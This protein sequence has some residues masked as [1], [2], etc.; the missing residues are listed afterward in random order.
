MKIA[1]IGAGFGGLSA[2]WDLRRAGH[3]V[4][5]FEAAD[6]VGGLASGF[7]APHWDWSVDKFYHHWFA[8]DKHLLNLM[9]E[10]GW[11]EDVIYPRPFTVLYYRDKWYPFD[12]IKEALLFPGLGYGLD[13]IRFGLVGVY[14]RLTNN[15]RTLENVTADAW[16]RRWAGEKVY[17]LMWEPLLQGKFGEKY[18]RQVNMAWMWAR[19][20]ARTTRLG[21]FKGGFQRF[22]DRFANRLMEMGVHI[23]LSTP[24]THLVQRGGQWQLETAAGSAEFERVLVTVSPHALARMAPDLP[25]DYLENLLRLK[26]MGAI[27][28]VFALKHQLSTEGY[29]WFN[30]PKAEGFPALALVEH[31]NFVSPEHFGGDH[32]VYLGDY[33]PPEH[34]YFRL[35]EAE[36]REIYLPA[37]KRINPNFSEDWVKQTWLFRAAYAQPIPL[38]GHSQHIPAVQ[39]PLDGLYYAGMSQ[40]YPWDRGTNYAIELGR[41]AAGLMMDN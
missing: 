26:H 10:L 30:L 38:T 31:T 6:Y 35:S 11:R 22:A 28:M 8:S 7:K 20:K 14:L 2:A 33:L 1:I 36:L 9:D 18:Y 21:T 12:A 37:L 40:V 17:R 15:W 41:R 27:V 24:V 3:E 19:L 32:I 4:T 16:M 23:H 5:I 25:P 34:P 13:K 29:Y 39:T